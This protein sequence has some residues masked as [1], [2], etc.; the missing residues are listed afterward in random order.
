MASRQAQ[1]LNEHDLEHRSLRL[2]VFLLRQ[3]LLRLYTEQYGERAPA[4]VAE[5]LAQVRD[6]ES[7]QGL[8]PAEQAMLLDET[9]EAF[10]D[11]DEH[12]DLIQAGAL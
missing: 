1:P 9:A 8:H 3:L 2:Q 11:V 5:R 6:A 12:L 10:A 7:G 4:V